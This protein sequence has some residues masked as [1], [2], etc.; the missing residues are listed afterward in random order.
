MSDRDLPKGTGERFPARYSEL[1]SGVVDRADV[2]ADIA[3]QM[4]E[5]D[6]GD[7]MQLDRPDRFDQE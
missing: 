4:E 7:L 2:R 6:E 1:V 5:E 3:R